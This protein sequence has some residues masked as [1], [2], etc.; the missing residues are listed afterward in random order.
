VKDTETIPLYSSI[1]VRK[2]GI[3]LHVKTQ[4]KKIL[5]N[6]YSTM[7]VWAEEHKSP[8]GAF[9][10]TRSLQANR[11]HRLNTLGWT[12]IEKSLDSRPVFGTFQKLRE[13]GAWDWRR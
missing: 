7:K 10:R 4:E 1:T 5:N 11:K 12:E 8:Q 2:V 9:R 6:T 13:G 3:V